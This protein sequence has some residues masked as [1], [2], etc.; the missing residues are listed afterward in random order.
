MSETLLKL[1][2]AGLRCLLGPAQPR[3]ATVREIAERLGLAVA[4]PPSLAADWAMG[5]EADWDGQCWRLDDF[6]GS[7]YMVLDGGVLVVKESR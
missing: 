6:G 4:V 2:S 5:L 1:A 3:R 7:L